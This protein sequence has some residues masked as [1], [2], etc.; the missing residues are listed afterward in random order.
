MVTVIVLAL[1]KTGIET[2]SGLILSTCIEDAPEIIRQARLTNPA[3]R[4]LV[5]CSLFH[6]AI[7]L[8][9][10]G[11][12]VGATGE[13]E[14]GVV[15]VKAITYLVIIDCATRLQQQEKTRMSLYY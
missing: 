14:V 8:H 2:A 15:F 5:R 6:D 1:L 12:G 3:L 7:S 13:A 10:A 9:K 11:A 4:I